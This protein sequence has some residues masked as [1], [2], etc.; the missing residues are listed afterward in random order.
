MAN[1][2]KG[3]PWVLDTASA[4]ALR[5]DQTWMVG[6]TLRGYST[7]GHKAV[8]KDSRGNIVMELIG[9]DDLSPVGENWQRPQT[10]RGLA[11]TTLD[12]GFVTVQIQ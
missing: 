7:S 6:A 4:T 11:L 1:D 12:S 9:N 3:R 2:L 5:P 8:F 10:V